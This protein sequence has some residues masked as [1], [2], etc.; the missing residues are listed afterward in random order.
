M[1][2]G[3]LTSVHKRYDIRIFKKE[4]LSLVDADNYEVYLIVADGLGDEFEQGIHIHDVGKPRSRRDRMTKTAKAI[5][6]KAV[7][8]NL[9]LY[10]MHDP[11]LIPSGLKLKK[12]G[13]KIVFDAH[14]D[15]PK[16]LLS[17]PYLNPLLLKILARAFN[18]YERRVLPKFDLII[19]ATPS[20]G[21]KFDSFHPNVVVINNYPILGELD[22]PARSEKKNRE[23]AYVGGMSRIRG[24]KEV[25]TAIGKTE[26]VKINLVGEFS[27][28]DLAEE[29][30]SLPGWSQVN[31]LGFLSRR[32]V[33]EVL[34][35]SMAGVVTFLPLPNHID[36]Q[37]N[38]LFEYMSAGL[39]VIASHF[40]LWRSV[41][42]G[43]QCGICVDPESPGAISEAINFLMANPEKAREMGENGRKAVKGKY[44]WSREKTNLVQ[45]YHELFS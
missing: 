44:N 15:L 31:E 40:D 11:E 35:R 27:E 24:I 17:K 43:E 25:I 16:Q 2:I 23:V 6:E 18:V 21:K 29:V 12:R 36:A 26:G 34:S 41:V 10:Q 30:R 5:Y 14:E 32:E 13:K 33:A 3:H 39:P 37:P 22:R 1:K 20:I 4:L 7:E 38:K 45:A 19:T 9:D 28:T 42:E 8:L